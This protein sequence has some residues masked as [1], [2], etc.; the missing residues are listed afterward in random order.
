MNHF[1]SLKIAKNTSEFLDFELD[2]RF[3]TT[4]CIANN[5]QLSDN[6]TWETFKINILAGHYFIETKFRHSR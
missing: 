5:R 2:I 1:Q 3:H 4:N 6:K